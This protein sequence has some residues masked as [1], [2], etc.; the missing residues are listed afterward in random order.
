[1]EA[2][3][4]FVPG[5]YEDV[6]VYMDHLIAVGTDRA[7]LRMNLSEMLD[8]TLPP[9]VRR[10]AYLWFER[11]DLLASSGVQALLADEQVRQ[12]VENSLA[13]TVDA[14][15]VEPRWTTSEDYE[16]LLGDATVLDFQIYR[17]RL[18]LGTTHGMLHADLID[19]GIDFHFAQVTKRTDARCVALSVRYGAVAASCEDD[20]LLM[21]FDEFG[22][23][24]PHFPTGLSRAAT[25]S[26]RSSWLGYNVV[27]Y[28][29]S[30]HAQGLRARYQVR[31][32][33]SGRRRDVVVTDVAQDE[34]MLG[35][36][37]QE[38]RD[39]DFVFNSHSRFFVHTE[40]G[41]FEVHQRAWS[42]NRLG[43]S[44]ASWSGEMDRPLSVV[45]AANGLAVET[46]SAIWLL[47]NET[48]H[49]IYEGEA[50]V[51]RSF[52][53]SVRYQNLIAVVDKEGLYLVSPFIR[54][55]SETF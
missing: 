13:T 7:V 23:L 37:S 43:A 38:L 14:F 44:L 34:E 22:E 31:S 19:D 25:I 15:L 9:S 50:I 36:V 28:V 30:S 33:R 55:Q 24:K 41:R 4:L 11:N 6:F 26:Q 16:R 53:Y 46:Y 3:R 35:P 18:F 17:Q 32:E 49:Q 40:D 12:V 52:P 54:A 21:S 51:L 2:L 48:V 20:G 27:N 29:D 39:A 1:M 10:L 8:T 45:A 42:R 47:G 5:E